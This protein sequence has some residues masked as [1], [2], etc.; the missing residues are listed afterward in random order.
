MEFKQ[1]EWEKRE[2]GCFVA[3]VAFGLQLIVGKVL[4]KWIWEIGNLSL[5][6]H[7]KSNSEQMAK[8]NAEHYFQELL[9]N[10]GKCIE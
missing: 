5:V 3:N 8:A 7:G 4:D 10:I 1:V 6:K 2:N 9:E